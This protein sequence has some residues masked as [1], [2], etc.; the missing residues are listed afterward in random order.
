M[1]S[2]FWLNADKAGGP[3]VKVLC[4]R[5]R[6]CPGVA[7]AQHFVSGFC[8]AAK[9]RGDYLRQLWWS[10]NPLMDAVRFSRAGVW[11]TAPLMNVARDRWACEVGGGM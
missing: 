7:V 5:R 9:K 8:P 10:F 3:T 11:W 4:D 1:N 6:R 2:C